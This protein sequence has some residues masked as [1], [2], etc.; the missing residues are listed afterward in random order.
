MC[1]KCLRERRGQMPDLSSA[2]GEIASIDANLVN[3]SVIHNINTTVK[4]IVTVVFVCL[5]VS[6]GKYDIVGTLSMGIYIVVMYILA[7]IPFMKGLKRMCP[8]LSAAVLLCIGNIFFDRGTVMNIGGFAVTGGIASAPVIMLKIIYSVM[9]A[10]LLIASSGMEEI[11]ASLRRLHVPDII[12]TQ[13]LLMYR[14]I[15]LLLREAKTTFEAY[16][17]RAPKQKGLHFK[18]WGTVTGQL[19]LRTIDRA[20][21][22]YESMLLR[23]YKDSIVFSG[24]SEVKFSD[25]V[26]LLICCAAFFALRFSDIINIIGSIFL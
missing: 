24:D 14:Y 17:L 5:T 8:A 23:G 26:F 21:A 6:F 20:D 18:T 22:V 19:L 4:L 16:S 7:D 1:L 15:S 9:A 13:I 12:V 10:Y 25:T 11:C 3:D 2:S